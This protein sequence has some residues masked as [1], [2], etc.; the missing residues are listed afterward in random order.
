MP[1]DTILFVSK[2]SEM[3]SGAVVN[4]EEKTKFLF[5]LSTRIH[6]GLEPCTPEAL[7][8]AAGPGAG[9]WLTALPTSRATTM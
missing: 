1:V 8:K 5:P 4:G 6:D 2:E 9:H 7:V 3:A